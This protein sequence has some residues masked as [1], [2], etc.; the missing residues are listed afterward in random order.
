MRYL[1]VTTTIIAGLAYTSSAMAQT[2]TA[3]PS[4]EE[5][6]YT[7]SASDCANKKSIRCPFDTTAYFCAEIGSCD[8]SDY[9][10]TECPTGGNC[11]NITCDGTTKHK[12]NSCNSGYEINSDST[13]CTACNFTS[14]PLSSCDANGS[15]SSYTC[16]GVTKFKLNSCNSGYTM[17]GNTCIVCSLSGYPLSSCPDNGNCSW[18]TC[19]GTT[20]YVLNSCKSGYTQ[21][22]NSCIDCSSRCIDMS[23]CNRPRRL[24]Y[25]CDCYTSASVC[26][27]EFDT[28]FTTCA[29]YCKASTDGLL[30]T[31]DKYMSNYCFPTCICEGEFE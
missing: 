3:A 4:C 16:D 8:F 20:K 26:C 31:E 19:D 12:L 29:A 14:Y 27:D 25:T 1:L 17:S 22:G 18:K 9:P 23:Y 28:K 21:S 13:T 11:S 10:L 30:S 2:C 6:G 5:M 15:C 24:D 7:Q